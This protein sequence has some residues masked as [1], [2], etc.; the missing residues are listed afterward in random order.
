MS[1]SLTLHRYWI[2]ANR[3]RELFDLSITEKDIE[4][5]KNFPIW[6]ADDPG[7]LMSHWYAALYVVIEGYQEIGLKDNIIDS[8]ITSPYV[9]L[10]RRYRNGVCHFQKDYFDNR[11]VNFMEPPDIVK[12][13]RSLN[14][15]FGRFF[16]EQA[17]KK[18]ASSDNNN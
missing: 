14:L 9:D 4:H 2:W 8:L 11:F 3:L 17:R 6:F 7:L 10:L 16:I 13:I 15:E 5:E 1:Y 12:W 18:K